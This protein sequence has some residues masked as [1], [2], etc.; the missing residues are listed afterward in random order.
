[1]RSKPLTR[2]QREALFRVFC[3]DNPSAAHNFPGWQRAYRRFRRTAYN[4]H[5]DCVLVAWKGMTL[6]IEPD[7]YTHS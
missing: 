7:G 3:R 4:S 2:L 1:M 6:G 5:M